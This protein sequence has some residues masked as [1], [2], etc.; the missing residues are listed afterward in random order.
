MNSNQIDQ[1]KAMRVKLFPI[2]HV[3]TNIEYLTY[4]FG[5][6]NLGGDWFD[7]M[8]YVSKDGEKYTRLTGDFTG[9]SCSIFG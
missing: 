6:A 9:F 4:S 3:K 2:V 7:C 8:T 5:K 1:L